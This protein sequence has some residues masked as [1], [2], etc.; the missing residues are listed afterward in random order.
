MKRFALILSL[1]ALPQVAASETLHDAL[2][3][4]IVAF[5]ITDVDPSTRSTLREIVNDPDMSHGNKVLSLHSIL[6]SEG[7]LRHVDIHGA[8]LNTA[9]ASGDGAVYA[10]ADALK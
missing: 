9:D 8:P 7:A 2:Q 5:D 1:A 3:D 10:E 6:D 4:Y